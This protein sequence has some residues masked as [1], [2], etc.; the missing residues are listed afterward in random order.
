MAIFQVN[1]GQLAVP[2]FTV[3]GHPFPEHHR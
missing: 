2:W 1:L 3:Y